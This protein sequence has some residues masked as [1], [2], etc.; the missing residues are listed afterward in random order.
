M[1]RTKFER[2][3]TKARQRDDVTPERAQWGV[4]RSAGM[5][6]KLVPPIL[7][8]RAKGDLT[9]AEFEALDYYREQA[10]LAQDKSTKDSCDFSVGG[11]TG[12]GE[13]PLTVQSAKGEK[14]RLDR[15]L[16]ALQPLVYAICV[17]DMS[18][19]QWACEKHGSRERYRNGR[20]I[21]LVPRAANAV[22]YARRE[23]KVA[24]ARL[25]PK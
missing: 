14:T 19:T 4:F 11:G 20:F 13:P 9:Q 21:E 18:L 6:R 15:H 25:R 2:K 7:T 12:R 22:M 16:G 10:T 23:L 5:A 24:A 17:K 8:L 3:Q 1:A